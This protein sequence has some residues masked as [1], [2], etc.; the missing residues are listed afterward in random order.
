VG[1]QKRISIQVIGDG[2]RAGEFK[3]VEGSSSTC[4]NRRAEWSERVIP[5]HGDV[6]LRIEVDGKMER[7]L[8]GKSLSLQKAIRC[9]FH[10]Y[11]DNERLF[12]WPI[13]IRWSLLKY[14][15]YNAEIHSFLR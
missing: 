7:F 15:V 6:N 1:I 13:A 14:P 11:N 5:A 9:A 8:P 3:V 10:S 2:S 4:I 12:R